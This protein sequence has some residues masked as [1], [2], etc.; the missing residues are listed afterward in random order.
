MICLRDL[1]LNSPTLQLHHVHKVKIEHTLHCDYVYL[2][3][4][5][6]LLH[7]LVIVTL[8]PST[9]QNPAGCTGITAIASAPTRHL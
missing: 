8:Y 4:C 7:H 2:A 1:H 5:T 3:T 9:Q 6:K